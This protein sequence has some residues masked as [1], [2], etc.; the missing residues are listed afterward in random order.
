MAKINDYA[1]KVFEIEK[2]SKFPESSTEQKILGLYNGIS[3]FSNSVNRND[4]QDTEKRFAAILVNLLSIANHLKIDSDSAL[5]DR[6]KEID[7]CHGTCER[8]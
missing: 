6:I 5:E 2:S 8:K 1:K 3:A 7:K 4:K